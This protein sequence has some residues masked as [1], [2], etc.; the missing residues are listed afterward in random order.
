MESAAFLQF[1]RSP[2]RQSSRLT[3]VSNYDP[4]ADVLYLSVGDP[5]PALAVDIGDGLILRYNPVNEEIV[6][7][8]VIGL[9]ARL[10][11]ELQD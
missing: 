3:V 11:A 7:I 10:Q 6:G 4:E 2:L 8:T 1:F 9:R 5:Q